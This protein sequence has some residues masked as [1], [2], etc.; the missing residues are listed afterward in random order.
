MMMPSFHSKKHF[1]YCQC[2]NAY[3]GESTS[4]D[5][6]SCTKEQE[7][8][9]ISGTATKW[10]MSSQEFGLVFINQKSIKVQVITNYLVDTPSSEINLANEEFMNIYTKRW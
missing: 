4:N 6:S 5:D 2:V 9:N 3:F 1:G 10:V 8:S 7:H